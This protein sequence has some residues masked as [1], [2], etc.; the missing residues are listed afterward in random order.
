MSHPLDWSTITHDP[1]RY[2]GMRMEM[3]IGQA[4]NRGIISLITPNTKN[5]VHG[6]TFVCH[7]CEH[8][9][10]DG[11]WQQCPAHM[12]FDIEISWILR[13]IGKQL[14]FTILPDGFGYIDVS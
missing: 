14:H 7:S 4:T 9:N 13:L 12:N 11:I 10:G 5:G 8:K 2:I 3:H 6:L 1:Q